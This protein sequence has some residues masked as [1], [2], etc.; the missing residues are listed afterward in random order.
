MYS[1][2]VKS[3]SI[4]IEMRGRSLGLGE[5]LWA[6]LDGKNKTQNRF[7][8]KQNESG[9]KIVLLIVNAG[10]CIYRVG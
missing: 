2:S 4:A 8:R 6:M 9:V 10:L 7:W 5:T 3:V 1:F